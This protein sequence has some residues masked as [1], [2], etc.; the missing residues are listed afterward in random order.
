MIASSLN[1]NAQKH[2]VT[3]QSFIGSIMISILLV[4]LL[5]PV[6]GELET[7]LG[8]SVLLTN[9]SEHHNSIVLS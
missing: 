8:Q 4:D 2:S 9:V 7:G 3:Y 6:V 1:N 5:Q